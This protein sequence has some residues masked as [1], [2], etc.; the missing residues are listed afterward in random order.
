MSQSPPVA[1]IIGAGANVGQHTAA[2][3]KAKG[4]Q[5]AVGSRNPDVEKNKAD[6][7][8][9]VTVDA[10]DIESIKAAFATVNTS[11]GTPSVFVFNA[12]VFAPPAVPDDPLSL[13]V[14]GMAAHTGMGVSVYAAAQQFISLARAAGPGFASVPKTFIATG[15]PLPWSPDLRFFGTN[16]QKIVQWRL[17]GLLAE[18]YRKENF[19]FYFATL[20]GSTGGILDHIPDFFTSGPQ[21]AKVYMHLIEQGE[22]VEWDYRFTLEAKQWTKKD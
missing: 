20:V 1:F 13:S 6:G 18:A 10:A 11:L 19:R 7:F 2:A 14:E 3:L 12:P 15:N 8:F 16:I 5:V 22:Q 4:Y 17:L 9:T 21:H